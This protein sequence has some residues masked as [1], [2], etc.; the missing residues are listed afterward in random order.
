M[1]SK[2]QKIAFIV[3]TTVMVGAIG[4]IFSANNT[5]EIH[6]EKRDLGIL[7]KRTT[8]EKKV[9]LNKSISFK[10]TTRE[11]KEP[12]QPPLVEKP[13]E[14][15]DEEKEKKRSAKKAEKK[16]TD[17]NKKAEK[18]K[19]SQKAKNTVA[20]R[21]V[22]G[23]PIA[24][25]DQTAM[26]GDTEDADFDDSSPQANNAFPGYVA[27]GAVSPMYD[28]TNTPNQVDNNTG[29]WSKSLLSSPSL[30]TTKRFID[31]FHAGE[32]SAATF[33]SI[34]SNTL[35]SE[36][37]LVRQHGLL[38]LSQTPSPRSFKELAYQKN[39]SPFDYVVSKASESLEQ[40]TSSYKHASIINQVLD[41]EDFSVKIEAIKIGKKLAQRNLASHEEDQPTQEG[42]EETQQRS[43]SSVNEQ[44]K[45]DTSEYETMTEKLEKISQ[46]SEGELRTI[47]SEAQ[48]FIADLLEKHKEANKPPEQT[49]PP[50]EQT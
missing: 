1:F 24:P 35:K 22:G 25:H 50:P 9:W 26:L 30:K 46:S 34:I 37:A 23:A 44:T 21:V 28:Q 12:E 47:A 3:V 49:P 31:A 41:D 6:E 2:K 18:K 13:Q 11:K 27:G 32:V 8:L 15:E 40:Y 19:G 16:K 17:D 4:M 39:N 45:I 7:G 36:N 5:R 38:A 43:I 10:K 14:D 33:Y 48:S 42:S 20:V 29:H